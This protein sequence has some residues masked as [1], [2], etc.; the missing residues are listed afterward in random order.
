MNPKVLLGVDELT[1]V[2]SI[3]VAT[4]NGIDDWQPTA[5]AMIS[6]FIE[7]SH[8]E[9]I[10]GKKKSLESKLPAGY[11]VAYDF[12]FNPWYF[13]I[14]YHPMHPK[15]GVI[16]KFS[17]YSWNTYCSQYSMNIKKFLV[18]IKSDLYNFRLSRVDFTVDYQNWDISVNEIYQ[19]L[20]NETLEI[21][22]LN[23]KKNHSKITAYEVNGVVSTFY[24]GS[25]KIGTRLFMRVYD[26]REE[27]L[28]TFGYR[29]REASNSTTWLRFEVVFRGLYAHQITDLINEIE[30]AKLSDLIANKVTEKFRFYELLEERYSNFSQ[31]LLDNFGEE[32]MKLKLESPRNNELIASINH[33][34]QGSGLFTVMYKCAKIWGERESMTLLKNLYKVYMD[35]YEPSED[36][37]LWV[38][39]NKASLENEALNDMFTNLKR[40]VK[41]KNKKKKKIVNEPSEADIDNFD[42]VDMQPTTIISHNS[43]NKKR[44]K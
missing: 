1:V 20:L 29:Y 23:D 18:S 19:G 43:L 31:A 22:D 38:K 35:T 10:F 21:R 5:E 13:A 16:V 33:L 8:I 24:I 17:A 25:R 30:E 34:A 14:A 9:S 40:F 7:L 28:Q 2:L 6:K 3:D 11:T 12:G 37:K 36:T 26:K 27:Q 4:L 15:M 41:S 32:F 42:N 39:K 44:G